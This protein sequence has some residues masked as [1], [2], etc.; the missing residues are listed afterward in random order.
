M[1][2]ARDWYARRD[3]SGWRLHL[4]LLDKLGRPVV[5]VGKVRPDEFLG[6][7]IDG[8]VST[9]GRGKDE[10]VKKAEFRGWKLDS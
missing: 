9:P 7:A 5:W 10:L 3:G 1:G 8:T 2:S 4:T 6:V